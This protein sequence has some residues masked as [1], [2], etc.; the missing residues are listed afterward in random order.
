M[1]RLL[2]SLIV[3]VSLAGE[4]GF[5]GCCDYNDDGTCDLSDFAFFGQHYTHQCM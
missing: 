1:K 4:T 5:S 3:L 2:V